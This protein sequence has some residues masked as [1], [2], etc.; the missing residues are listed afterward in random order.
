M[1]L[2]KI[3][4]KRLK[5]YWAQAGS[6]INSLFVMLDDEIKILGNRTTC[7]YCAEELNIYWRLCECEKEV[8]CEKCYKCIQCKDEV[9]RGKKRCL[10]CMNIIGGTKC[11]YCDSDS[12][13]Y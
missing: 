7:G 1:L 8:I 4:V 10:I 13:G 12:D 11:G 9:I 6:D 5:H 2:N 3:I